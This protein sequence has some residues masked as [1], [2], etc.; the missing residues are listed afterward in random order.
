MSKKHVNTPADFDKGY[1]ENEIGLKGIVYFGIGLF[2][3]IVITFGLMWA[4][5][6]TMRDS[7]PGQPDEIARQGPPSGRAAIAGCTRIWR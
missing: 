1:E 2:L 3:L 5:L 4:F 7:G 6:G